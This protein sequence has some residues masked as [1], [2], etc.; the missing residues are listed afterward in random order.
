LLGDA[1]LAHLGE[2]DYDSFHL[3]RP[4]LPHLR[5]FAD[6]DHQL[7]ERGVVQVSKAWKASGR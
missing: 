6:L 3:S 2:F 7:I 4:R 1:S 5:R